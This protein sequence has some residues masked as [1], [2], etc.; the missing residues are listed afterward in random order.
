M[1]FGN[2][3]NGLKSILST[4]E[5]IKQI[6]NYDF[7]K[8]Y[9]IYEIGDIR[10]FSAKDIQSLQTYVDLLDKGAVSAEQFDDIFA[11]ASDEVI[12]SAKGFESLN[13]SFKYGAISEKEYA[14]ATQNLALTQRTATAT[15]KA[16]SIALNTIANIG[17]MVAINLAIKGI[18]ALA[19]K[20]IVTKEE[21]AEVRETAIQDVQDL[22]N[23]IDELVS[24]EEEVGE[25]IKR[26][27]EIISST[28]DIAESKDELLSIQG[29]IIAKY[30]AEKES[31]D[32]LNDTYDT[33]IAK[34]KELSDEEYKR[35]ERKNAAKIA[36]AEKMAGYNIGFYT[37]EEYGNYEGR[38]RD[39][40]FI[41]D[42]GRKIY[43][44]NQLENIDDLAASLYV[45]EDVSK[46]IKGIWK[47]IDGINLSAG[48]LYL[49]GTLQEAYEQLGA[50]IDAINNSDIENKEAAL[51]PISAQYEKIGEAI[52][53]ID[54]Y[55][56]KQKEHELAYD[57]AVGDEL[58]KNIEKLNQY[59]T[60]VGDAR[61]AWFEHFKELQ[62]GF[63]NTIQ[64]MEKALQSL[65]DGDALSSTDFWGLVELDKNHILTDIQMVGDKFVVNQ[66]QLIA[67][68]DD[69]INQQ[70]ESL[71]L[72][73][74][75][76]VS[77]QKDLQA[78]IDLAEAELAVLGARG[79][80]NEAYRQQFKA[81]QDAIKQ[82]K[83]NLADYGEQIRRNNVVI[84]S[85]N[86]RLGNT[87]D[88]TEQLKKQLEQ[89]NNELDDYVKAFEY[90]ID[91]NIDGL[92]DELDVL[93][94]QKDAL[95]EELDVLNEQKDTIQETIDN[96]KTVADLVQDTIEKRKEELE[97]EKKAIEDTYN[98]RI[99]K[100]KEETEQREDAYEY[101]QKLAN[102]EN[103]KN[104]K[105]RV[106]DEAR[107]W[108]YESVKEDV[109]K[110][111]NDLAKFENE[112]TI[113]S[114]EK[115]RDELTKT[116]DEQIE[117]QTKYAEY[118]K[119]TLD[120][121]VL[122]E[123]ELLAEQILGSKWREDIANLDIETAE[124][125]RT[126]YRNH[127]T[128]LQNITRTEIKLK[129]E[130]IK[131][132]DAE[133][134]SKQEQINAWKKYKTDVQNAV[135]D[136][137]ATQ[138]DYMTI[139]K[140]LDE[141]EPLTLQNRASAFETFKDRVVTAIGNITSMQ[142]QIDNMTASF[143]GDHTYSMRFNVEN[144]GD[145]DEANSTL[146]EIQSRF[147]GIADVAMRNFMAFNKQQGVVTWGTAGGEDGGV[148]GS[149]EWSMPSHANGGVV[150]YT[151]VA[152][153]HGTK[154]K[155]ETIFNA[156]DSA[157][158]YDMVHNTPN[159][160]ADMLNQATKLSGFKLSSN[161]NTNNSSVSIGAIN[162]YANNPTE[163]TRGLD[164]TLDRYFRTKL[165]QSYTS[166]Q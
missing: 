18:S 54:N 155:S 48:D 78:T 146:G 45:V 56:Q 94:E 22:S 166:K 108:R 26:Y 89:L 63:D 9:K 8:L 41:E 160:M 68:K 1:I 91:R 157:K 50:L 119:E 156:N 92:Q 82:A 101:A 31:L 46:D 142:S 72:E 10:A 132:K 52:Q 17:I 124:K 112:Q 21:L 86:A 66:E 98:E 97:A 6:A 61:A 154:Q 11:D 139:V 99:N 7:G 102:L 131:A 77:K 83:V 49:S 106:Y 148:W 95:Q 116:I 53:N 117:E 16:L 123:K 44:M 32:L 84:D 71:K 23:G 79:M 34:V 67:L 129:E 57:V 140:E 103:A 73:N 153:L 55:T 163:L 13:K 39:N 118:Y 81:A 15:S 150:D 14:T 28:N 76:L 127:N 93:N 60:A 58:T 109:V 59:T 80:A 115:E 5:K 51:A 30:G 164:K 134:K 4:F 35:W 133:I 113:K 143:D 27:K 121:I 130:A 85:W 111:E 69:Y 161:E 87:V 36:R 20:L 37:P 136:A 137:K 107:G 47:D 74:D 43:F 122:Q 158:L 145:I 128:A 62:E 138:E 90:R 165:T 100:L 104:N 144:K 151:G 25:L 29:D 149:P 141:K 70:V 135:K 120:E 75:N 147:A 125:F 19:D 40:G 33:T 38:I 65:A 96:Y 2:F 159:L 152:M 114:L 64:P 105:R 24:K 88:L 110:A 3:D 42:D 162:V 126:E 12:K